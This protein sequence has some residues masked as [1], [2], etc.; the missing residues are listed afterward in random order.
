MGSNKGMVQLHITSVAKTSSE[1]SWEDV[2]KFESGVAQGRINFSPFISAFEVPG[3]ISILHRVGH[4][5][6]ASNIP[7][8]AVILSRTRWVS[9]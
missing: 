8:I 7:N 3:D 2:A 9:M 1:L 5:P 4:L 6:T